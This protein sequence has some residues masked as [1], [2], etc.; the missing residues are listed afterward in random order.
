MAFREVVELLQD[1]HNAPVLLESRR[2]STGV[3]CAPSLVGRVMTT[4]FDT[5]RGMALGWIGAD[6]IQKG[7]GDPVFNNYGGEERPWF[8]PEGSQFGLHFRSRTQVFENYRVQAGMSWQP[9]LTVHRTAESVLMRARIHLQ[10]LAGTRFDLNVERLIRIMEY[11]PYT[12]GLVGD[13]IDF[14][15][16][17]SETS[18]R[19]MDRNPILP[20]TGLI[21]CWTPGLHPH[22]NGSVVVLP[23]REGS[24]SDLG[25]PIRQDY[26]KDLCLGGELPAIVGRCGRTAL[27]S[28]RKAASG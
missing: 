23:L 9:Y 1:T 7:P 12:A 15:G 25:P 27:Y 8:G 16:F 19:N 4:T 2:H 6:A 20:E 24:E 17:Q 10:N 22:Q 18:V 28:K 5:D 13:R 14:V 21:C 26:F 11:C 3:V